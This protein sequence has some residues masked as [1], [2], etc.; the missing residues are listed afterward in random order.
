VATLTRHPPESGEGALRLEIERGLRA[1]V[2]DSEPWP[3]CAD[4][5]EK[6]QRGRGK[7]YRFW[8]AGSA[9]PAGRRAQERAGEDAGQFLSAAAPARRALPST[10]RQALADELM[11]EDGEGR[12]SSPQGGDRRAP[13][14]PGRWS[15]PSLTSSLAWRSRRRAR[16]ARARR[17]PAS[18]A[19]SMPCAPL[20]AA[21]GRPSFVRSSAHEDCMEIGQQSR[22]YLDSVVE[23]LAAPAGLLLCTY[24]EG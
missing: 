14:R 21:A 1:F 22:D 23:S 19:W 20:G 8:P 3:S 11:L 18:S 6:T 10:H 13:A 9:S 4:A 16:R 17:G 24:R 12:R 7:C 2:G 15:G 5:F